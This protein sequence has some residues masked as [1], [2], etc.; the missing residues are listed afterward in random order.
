MTKF[1]VKNQVTDSKLQEV[2]QIIEVIEAQ[3][4]KSQLL[5][6][7]GEEDPSKVHKEERKVVF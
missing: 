7:K 5:D 2:A 6:K 3:K 1:K 4:L